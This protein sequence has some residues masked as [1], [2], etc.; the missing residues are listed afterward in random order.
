[1][2]LPDGIQTTGVRIVGQKIAG[3]LEV[4]WVATVLDEHIRRAV[5]SGADSPR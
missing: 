4:V 2:G 3:P 5:S 1:M